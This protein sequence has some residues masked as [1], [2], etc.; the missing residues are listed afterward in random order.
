MTHRHRFLLLVAVVS[1]GFV[2][3]CSSASSSSG[4]SAGTGARATTMT[5]SGHYVRD[6]SSGG[7]I[8]ELLFAEGN[9]YEM[10]PVGCSNVDS[11]VV[12]GSYDFDGTTLTL[13]D[14]KTG[15]VTSIP[16][17]NIEPASRASSDAL[18][19]GDAL[20]VPLDIGGL[21]SAADA[22]LVTGTDAGL[23]DVAAVGPLLQKIDA[24]LDCMT[25]NAPTKNGVPEPPCAGSF[26]AEGTELVLPPT[27]TMTSQTVQQQP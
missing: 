6:P 13:T 11:C 27:S 24:L 14:G 23:I 25:Q 7:T 10:L 17:S 21:V 5:L 26:V 2:W 20:R 19:H 15:R 22:G 16:L 18:T 3:G 9:Q 8:Q 1:A 12:S 4:G